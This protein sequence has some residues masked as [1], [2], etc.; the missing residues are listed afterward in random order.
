M[1]TTRFLNGTMFEREFARC[2]DEYENLTFAVAWCGDSERV[3][4]FHHF[5]K[6]SG[7]INGLVGVGMHHTHPNAFPWLQSLK[8]D[9]R[10]FRDQVALFHPKVY[11]FEQ[12]T[13]Y[14]V[15][16]GS[17]N[18]THAG[19]YKNIEVNCLIEGQD[20]KGEISVL[21]GLI[22]DWRTDQN[23][24]LP[25]SKWLKDYAARFKREADRRRQASIIGAGDRDDS[26]ASANWL[27]Q[28]DWAT[29]Y[30]MVKKGLGQRDGGGQGYFDVL[31]NAKKNIP[32]PWSRRYFLEIDNR[33]LMGGLKPYGW[34]GHVAASG[35]VR[36][37]LANGTT[38]ELNQVVR[39]INAIAA[40]QHPIPW[41][42]LQTQ[43]VTLTAL[44]PTMKVWG[45]FLCITRPDL[46]CTIA[47]ESVRKNLSATLQLP[48]TAFSEPSGYIEL[49]KLLHGSPWFSAPAP[50]EAWELQ[51]WNYRV[52]LLDAIFH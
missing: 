51:V 11:I 6:I 13:R 9:I 49:L 7:K 25:D 47:S 4:P 30:T 39:S 27:R 45:R 46:Y 3:T 34:L 23:S 22:A 44:G 12:G 19:F 41:R 10:V 29:Y 40:L 28:A 1:N 38:A 20:E 16:I 14:A 36:R 18:L 15:F 31:V 50:K 33:R 17:S 32:T 52:A 42:K 35:D 26:V 37:L 43:L 48:A 24:H 21:R 2:C 5:A 8:A